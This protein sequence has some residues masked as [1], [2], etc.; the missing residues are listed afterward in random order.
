MEDLEQEIAEQE[1]AKDAAE[2]SEEKRRQRRA[3][4]PLRNLGALPT[5]LPRDEVVINVDRKECPCC[6][7][8]L[9]LIGESRTEM[10]D[11]VPAQLRVKVTRR[12]RYGCRACEGRSCRRP[13]RSGRSMA[14]W[15]PRH[16]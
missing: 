12:P 10:L 3:A 14:G 6:G 4:R 16:C 11:R 2:P 9:H 8:A 13:R 7:G 1:A 15:Q 5:H